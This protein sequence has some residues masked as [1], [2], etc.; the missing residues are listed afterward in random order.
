MNEEGLFDPQHK[1]PLPAYPMD[2]A[3]VT[4][5]NTAYT[6]GVTTATVASSATAD[7]LAKASDVKSY[8]DTTVASSV[9]AIKLPTVSTAN[10]FVTVT[11]NVVDGATDYKVGVVTAV[12][13]E[14]AEAG[15]LA[16][17]KD[18]KD[19]ID[20]KETTIN[21]NIETKLSWTEL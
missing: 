3:L 11:P 13:S 15:K 19:Y 1:K 17:A 20:G 2:V 6:V 7:G 4:G 9:G 16:D 8:V 12:V 10:S 5:N 21:N 14:V 18:V